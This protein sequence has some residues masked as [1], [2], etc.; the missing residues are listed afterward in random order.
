MATAANG[1]R[2]M[3]GQMVNEVADARGVRTTSRLGTREGLDR[4]W[5]AGL[6]LAVSG[7]YFALSR[8]VVALWSYSPINLFGFTSRARYEGY[9]RWDAAWYFLIADRGYY[10]DG[11]GKQAAVA[12][13]PAYPAAMRLVGYVT[14]DLMLAGVLITVASFAIALVLLHRWA[15]IAFP[16]RV[17]ALTVVLVIVFPYAYY[18]FGP[19]YSDALFIA[20]AVGAFLLLERRH[21]W[22]AAAV[23]AVASAERP[24]G[25]A[26]VIGLLIRSLELDG[27]LSTRWS[28]GA[29]RPRRLALDLGRLHPRTL[30]PAAG[31]AGLAAYCALLWVRF[32]DPFAFMK[33]ATADG[34][35]R[36]LAVSTVLKSEFFRLLTAG[37][38]TVRVVTIILSAALTVVALA[39]LPAVLRKLG[40]G[41]FAYCLIVILLPVITS[42]DFFGMG[43]YLLAPF[44]IYA[45]AASALTRRRQLLL[46]VPAA[47]AATLLALSVLFVRGYYLS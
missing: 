42:P 10:Y 12:F 41:Y 15:S 8:L 46:G 34:W 40:P 20:T 29:D 11:P 6:A 7:F 2:T 1:H 26:L 16:P 33:A 47:F 45:V 22:L 35:G 37:E 25:A 5:P 28:P 21:P 31:I 44:P 9:A 38:F 23:C 3:P 13:F 36:N 30:A 17:A 4:L 18:L 27:V 19:L 43:R 14:G 39:L 24:I 32:D